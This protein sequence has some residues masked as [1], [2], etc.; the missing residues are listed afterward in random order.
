MFLFSLISL[1]LSFFLIFQ[2]PI[3]D[4]LIAMLE[5]YS[6]DLEG[7]VADRTKELAEEKV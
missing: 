6:T 4:N 3:V 7:V 5:K 2:G 1:A